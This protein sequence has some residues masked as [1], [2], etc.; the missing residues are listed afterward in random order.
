MISTSASLFKHDFWT[1]KEASKQST[2]QGLKGLPPSNGHEC[3]PHRWGAPATWPHRPWILHVA[4]NKFSGQ[5]A[6]LEEYKLKGNFVIH[7]YT[8]ESDNLLYKIHRRFISER[9][10][11]AQSSSSL[12]SEALHDSRCMKALQG[13][14][15]LFMSEDGGLNPRLLPFQRGGTEAQGCRWTDHS[16]TVGEWKSLNSTLGLRGGSTHSCLEKRL[17][18]QN[19]VNTTPLVT[20]NLR[21]SP[22]IT[23]HLHTE[24]P[25]TPAFPAYTAVAPTVLYQ[26]LSA[27]FTSSPSLKIQVHNLSD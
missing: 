20:R 2:K 17:Y 26:R 22:K 25:S 16:H 10:R 4:V 12:Q 21:E 9:W 18:C 19:Y 24:L 13:L 6:G 3:I 7:A 14:T 11:E 5:Q 27:F 8:C 1:N 15:H 23:Y